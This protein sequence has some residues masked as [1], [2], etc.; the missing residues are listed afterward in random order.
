MAPKRELFDKLL[1][2]KQTV[3][4]ERQLGHSGEFPSTS[5]QAHILMVESLGSSQ[6]L[7]HSGVADTTFD[8]K[9][10]GCIRFCIFFKQDE[11]SLD[12]FKTSGG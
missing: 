6:K 9:L 7:C 3:C 11:V 2:P 1:P 4:T 8:G 12:N 5:K 10:V